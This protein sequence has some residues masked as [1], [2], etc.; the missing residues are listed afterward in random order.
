MTEQTPGDV[1]EAAAAAVR[2][3]NKA[4]LPPPSAAAVTGAA[5]EGTKVPS[6]SVSHGG[7]LGESKAPRSLT[8]NP[9]GSAPQHEA[10]FVGTPSASGAPQSDSNYGGGGTPSDGHQ[11]PGTG[12]SWIWP[13]GQ[14]VPVDGSFINPHHD[15]P[16]SAVA[17]AGGR[18]GG[19]LVHGTS[20]SA[21]GAAAAGD[22][23]GGGENMA[24]LLNH[25]D[26]YSSIIEPA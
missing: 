7:N 21:A 12:K 16:P 15:A 22:E 23:G 5:G 24:S 17:A 2:D 18:G 9:S 20:P 4:I 19:G 3:Q 14:V 26:S 6:G 10:C 8:L 1:E 13:N 11:G 25:L